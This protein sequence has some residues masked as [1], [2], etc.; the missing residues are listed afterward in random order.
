MTLTIKTAPNIEFHYSS[1]NTQLLLIIERITNKSVSNY[2]ETKIWKPLGKA[3]LSLDR[4]DEN[5]MEKLLLS[6]QGQ[7][8]LPNLED[9]ISTKELGR[10]SDCFKSMGRTTHTDPLIITDIITTTIGNWTLKYNS[11]YAVGLYGQYL[12]LYPKR[13]FKLFDLEIPHFPITQIIGKIYLFK[14]LIS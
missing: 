1:A 13:I 6:R 14:L 3:L 12:Y 11:F 8:I 2:L 5:G 4:K 9:C 7:L 10:K